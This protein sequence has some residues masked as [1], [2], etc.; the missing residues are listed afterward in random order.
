[1]FYL[2]SSLNSDVPWRS[3]GNSW[4]SD[5]CLEEA[6]LTAKRQRCRNDSLL[7]YDDC[8]LLRSNFT[9]PVKEY[10]YRQVLQKSPGIDSF[11]EVRWPLAITLGLCW[12]ACYFC[13]WKGVKWTG[14][15]SF[16]SHI[17]S[18]RATIQEPHSW[19]ISDLFVTRKI[20]FCTLLVTLTS[21]N[22]KRL[23]WRRQ[24]LTHGSGTMLGVEVDCEEMADHIVS[25]LDWEIINLKKKIFKRQEWRCF[26][27][28]DKTRQKFEECNEWWQFWFTTR[29]LVKTWEY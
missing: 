6:S 12:I 13:I 4:N 21:A 28:E 19:S 18:N 5:Y 23:H 15:V 14:K 27:R 11:G 8:Q 20:H 26:H 3:C 22:R 25:L 9:N 16:T 7:H 17:D 1:M 10:W 24:N 2:W 29:T